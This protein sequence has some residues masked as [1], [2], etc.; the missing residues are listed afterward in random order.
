MPVGFSIEPGIYLEGK[1]G[2]RSE[3]DMYVSQSEGR[4]TGGE[5]QRDMVAILA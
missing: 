1:F 4:V 2:A 5:P 3:I